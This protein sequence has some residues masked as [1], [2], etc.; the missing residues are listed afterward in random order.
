MTRRCSIPI[1]E[2]RHRTSQLPKCKHSFCD[3]NTL[4]PTTMTN[5]SAT[6]T[7][8]SGNSL[9]SSDN[10]TGTSVTITNASGS[11][12]ARFIPLGATLTHLWYTCPETNTTRDIVLGFDNDADYVNNPDNPYF[13][14]V[15]G[16]VANRCVSLYFFH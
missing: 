4:A 9:L 10:N 7:A 11:V 13:G 5:H 15:V 8:S 16:R 2:D 12:K 1:S 6:S 3:N 14:C